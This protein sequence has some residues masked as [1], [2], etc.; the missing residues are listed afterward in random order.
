VPGT[1]TAE[2][3]ARIKAA[4]EQGAV[5]QS[6]A[7]ANGV[8]QKASRPR[9]AVSRA[10]KKV[11]FGVLSAVLLALAGYTGAVTYAQFSKNQA[12]AETAQEQLKTASSLEEKQLYLQF[13]L[14]TSGPQDVLVLRHITVFLGFVVMFIGALLVLTGIEASYDLES[15]GVTNSTTLKTSSPGLV[16]ITLGALLILGAL[17]R[18]VNVGT[19]S[20]KGAASQKGS[21][22]S[23]GGASP[24]G[25]YAAEVDKNANYYNGI[26]VY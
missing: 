17:F 15:K 6:A 25:G 3:A 21:A 10:D 12:L 24:E 9:R 2:S 5:D 8:A 16:L 20:A 14:L 22:D 1:A 13:L 4:V 18:S 23:E 7:A 11:L 26:P 19:V